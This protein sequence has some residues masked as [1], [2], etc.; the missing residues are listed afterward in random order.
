MG[1]RVSNVLN[2][3]EKSHAASQKIEFESPSPRLSPRAVERRHFRTAFS[4][5]G[6]PA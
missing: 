4:L 1:T 3:R 5:T 2:Q 6:A